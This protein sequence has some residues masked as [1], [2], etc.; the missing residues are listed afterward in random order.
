LGRCSINVSYIMSL[1]TPCP[2]CPGTEPSSYLG[3][4]TRCT[5][6]TLLVTIRT[7]SGRPFPPTYRAYRAYLKKSYCLMEAGLRIRITLLWIRIQLF[8]FHFNAYPDPSPL[9]SDS[10]LR[11]VVYR[12][13]R[14]HFEPP[15][16]ITRAYA[17]CW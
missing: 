8:S 17:A 7:S 2:L 4:P 16:P 10:Y 14:L 1:I 15:G 13:S 5:A 12:P 3:D 6:P 9:Q 11:P